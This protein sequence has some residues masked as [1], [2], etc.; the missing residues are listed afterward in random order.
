L[1]QG[2]AAKR[3]RPNAAPPSCEVGRGTMGD[4]HLSQARIGRAGD[5]DRTIGCGLLVTP[6]H[7]V[8]C[9]HVVAQA[10]GTEATATSALAAAVI[11]ILAAFGAMAWWQWQHALAQETEALAAAERATRARQEAERL[12]NFMTVEL[13]QKLAP[14]GKLELLQYTQQRVD[15]YYEHLGIGQPGCNAPAGCESL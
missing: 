8:T 6:R 4:P 7:V 14:L 5:P 9:A 13:R 3:I 1:Y 2:S 11:L 12:V 15:A 10:L